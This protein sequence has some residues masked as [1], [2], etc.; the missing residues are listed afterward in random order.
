MIISF[1]CSQCSIWYERGWF[2]RYEISW[3]FSAI[4]A[5][6]TV[7]CLSGQR[8]NF[9]WKPCL[10]MK[11]LILFCLLAGGGLLMVM[12]NQ[13]AQSCNMGGQEPKQKLIRNI[14][15]LNNKNVGSREGLNRPTLIT[16]VT[17]SQHST[18]R[19]FLFLSP[20]LKR[21]P[22]SLTRASAIDSNNLQIPEESHRPWYN[23][24][25]VHRRR[26]IIS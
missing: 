16:Q 1:N 26:T 13:W 3:E 24:P 14:T 4:S 7:L 6:I 20:S 19:S 11:K 18:E 5:S 17:N 21:G 9:I 2:L 25:T 10:S 12:H 15:N 23:V 22:M 8:W